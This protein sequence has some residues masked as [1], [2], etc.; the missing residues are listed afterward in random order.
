M[1][2]CDIC[3]APIEFGETA[4]ESSTCNH[5]FHFGHILEWLKIVEK[6]PVCKM[7]MN[8]NTLKLIYFSD[9]EK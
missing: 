6:C 5:T 8:R 7:Q 9:K 4:V 3:K 2:V 1:L